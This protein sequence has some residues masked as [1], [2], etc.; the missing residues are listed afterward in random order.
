M[1]EQNFSKK[2]RQHT[3]TI[4]GLP[5]TPVPPPL[6]RNFFVSTF[7]Y[8]RRSLRLAVTLGAWASW[9]SNK[10]Q[11]GSDQKSALKNTSNFDLAP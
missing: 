3:G 7:F 10:E 4:P 9:P 6:N 1:K 5:A 2:F 11:V 8:A